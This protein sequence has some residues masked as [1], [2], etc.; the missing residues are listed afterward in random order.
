MR[1]VYQSDDLQCV[2]TEDEVRRYEYNQK[3]PL[4]ARLEN[5]RQC[6][7]VRVLLEKYP[8]T[9]SGFWEIRGEDTN[10]DLGW[11]NHQP[12]IATVEG[13]LLQAMKYAA[14]SPDFFG[15]GT[16]G[17]IQKIEVVKF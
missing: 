13:T 3:N 7:N 17:S 14:Q 1:R 5:V 16:G 12:Y 6:Y 15:W 11:H 2:G 8:E 4:H 9:T 10:C